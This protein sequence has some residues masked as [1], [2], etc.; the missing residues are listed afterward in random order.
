MIVATVLRK[1]GANDDSTFLAKILCIE[2]A[3]RAGGKP[4][5]YKVDM[6]Y[7]QTYHLY[8]PVVD[9]QKIYLDTYCNW[10][11]VEPPI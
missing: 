11:V 6:K 3:G 9:F 4:Q 5:T 1:G 8:H 2:P 10:L 7:P